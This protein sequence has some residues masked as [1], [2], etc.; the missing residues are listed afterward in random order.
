M[1][2]FNRTMLDALLKSADC[3]YATLYENDEF[4]DRVLY[5]NGQAYHLTME[6]DTE[7]KIVLTAISYAHACNLP[8]AV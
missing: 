5:S 8:G 3:W 7:A 2:Q 1:I 4:L 6:N